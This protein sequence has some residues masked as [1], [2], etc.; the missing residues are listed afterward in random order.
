ME[1]EPFLPMP[2]KSST[3]NASMSCAS[4]Y[5]EGGCFKDNKPLALWCARKIALKIGIST[6][7][8]ESPALI[9]LHKACSR[10]DPSRGK[11]FSSFA[12]PTIQ[13]E[14][15]R[16][17]RD[18]SPV[19]R[20]IQDLYN[21]GKILERRGNDQATADALNM[22]LRQWQLIKELSRY[23]F[24]RSLDAKFYELM[25]EYNLY[26]PRKGCKGKAWIV[27]SPAG[28]EVHIVNLSRFCRAHG[29]DRRKMNAVGVGTR[30]D[31]DG[32]K[33]RKA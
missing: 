14:I 10:F 24:S 32:W 23:F 12:V 11:A 29:L 15:W 8:L 30:A 13:G 27:V 28:D 26:A 6:T 9:G 5:S 22:L 33:C 20:A 16:Y 18:T 7:E 25:A 3:S 31:C 19:P 4:S 21:R 17:L 2:I 1:L